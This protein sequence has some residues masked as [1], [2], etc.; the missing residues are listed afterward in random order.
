MIAKDIIPL[1]KKDV[2]LS[3]VSDIEAELAKEQRS[4]LLTQSMGFEYG[5]DIVR[6][7]WT[8]IAS[9]FKKAAQE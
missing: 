3:Y 5:Y 8:V 6:D 2:L 4:Q 7:A 9:E 1:L